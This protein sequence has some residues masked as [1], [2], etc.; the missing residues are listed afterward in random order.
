MERYIPYEKMSKKQKKEWNAKKRVLWEGNP[1]TRKT[2]NKKQYNR[3]K[4]QRINRDDF[5]EPFFYLPKTGRCSAES[6]VRA[7]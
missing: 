6:P 2:E 3:K 1:V 4:V 5:A 7:A